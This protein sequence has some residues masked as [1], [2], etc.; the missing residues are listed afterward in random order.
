MTNIIREI[1]HSVLD[2]PEE[3]L[4]KWGIEIKLINSSDKNKVE[5]EFCTSLDSEQRKMYDEAEKL[6]GFAHL[7]EC[8]QRFEQGF[9]IGFCLAQQLNSKMNN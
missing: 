2:K 9:R 7:D 6:A 3:D 5:H 4:D 1:F 8:E